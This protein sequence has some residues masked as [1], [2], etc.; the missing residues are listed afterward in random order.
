MVYRVSGAVCPL[1]LS[2]KVPARAFSHSQNFFSARSWS[3]GYFFLYFLCLPGL[4]SSSQYFL[5]PAI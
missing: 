2:G 1:L 4:L 5:L 3:T